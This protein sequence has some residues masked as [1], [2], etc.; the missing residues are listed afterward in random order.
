MAV[1]RAHADD[2]RSEDRKADLELKQFGIVG[3]SADS[4]AS[5]PPAS[6]RRRRNGSFD[7]T[8]AAA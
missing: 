7:D 4:A 3:H 2:V 8:G 1:A 5:S 6:R